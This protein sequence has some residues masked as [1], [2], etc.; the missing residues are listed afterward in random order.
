[1]DLTLMIFKRVSF[2]IIIIQISMYNVFKYNR[3]GNISWK[4]K[5]HCWNLCWFIYRETFCVICICVQFQCTWTS[6]TVWRHTIVFWYFLC[7]KILEW[8]VWLFKW[9][10]VFIL[11]L[12]VVIEFVMD[13]HIFNVDS[14][15]NPG[16][17]RLAAGVVSVWCCCCHLF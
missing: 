2:L 3:R 17:S 7:C 12:I 5:K 6:N 14:L 1:M 9:L 10:L 13:S 8:E 4:I 11:F 16:H 15:L